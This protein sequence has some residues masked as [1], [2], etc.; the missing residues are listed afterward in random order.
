[1]RQDHVVEVA[2]LAKHHEVGSSQSSQSKDKGKKKNYPLC[3]HCGKMDHPPFRCWR[4]PDAKCNKCNQ[5]GHEAVI[6]KG[7]FQQ[8]EANSKDVEQDEEDQIFVATCFSARSCSECW[9]I[10]SGY[11]NHMTY[12]KLFSRI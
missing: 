6:C 3:E 8:H 11:T 4:R 2:L 9:L 1:M 12:I 10:D 5:L 7:K